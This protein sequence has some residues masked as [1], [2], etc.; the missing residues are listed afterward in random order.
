L[1][2][3]AIEVT[4]DGKRAIILAAYFSPSRPLIGADLTVFFH[5]GLPVLMA[6]DLNA[7][8]VDWNCRLGTRWGK[9]LRDYADENS[10]LMIFGPHSAAI[11]L[12]NPSTTPDALDIVI[13]KKLSFPVYLNSCSA[14]SSDHLPVLI[15]T[16]CHSSFHPPTDRRDFRRTDWVNFHTHWKI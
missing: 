9:L 7:K 14:L 12:Y 16:A 8:H 1:E 6:G 10:C 2:A 3:T 15:H 11:K 5:G 13:T 4:S